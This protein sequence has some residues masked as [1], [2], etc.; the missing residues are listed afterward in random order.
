MEEKLKREEAPEHDEGSYEILSWAN[1]GEDITIRDDQYDFPWVL[2]AVRRCRKRGFRFRLVD[3]GKFDISQLEWLGK[4]GADFY[5]SDGS[6]PSVF[7]LELMN[8][9]CR[10]GR[11]FVAYFHYGPLEAEESGRR[12]IPSSFQSL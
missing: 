2:D 8:K 1:E 12:P 7:E 5:T 6:R 9:A 10:R 3:S 4:A 11:A